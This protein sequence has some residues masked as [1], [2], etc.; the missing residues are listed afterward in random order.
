[1]D[2]VT[3]WLNSLSDTDIRLLVRA[4]VTVLVVL[5]FLLRH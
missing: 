4:G 5:W 2:T 1:M 3:G